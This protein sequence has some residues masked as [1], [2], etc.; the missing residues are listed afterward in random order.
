MHQNSGSQLAKE[1]YGSSEWGS[2]FWPYPLLLFDLSFW[3]CVSFR[4]WFDGITRFLSDVLLLERQIERLE[5]AI[6][7]SSDWLE[8]QY[9]MAELDQL[10]DLY[11]EPD[12][13]AA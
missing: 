3:G 9:L 1:F 12:V 13:E 4:V 10:K 5:R 11:E 6:E 8:I 2:C 7:L